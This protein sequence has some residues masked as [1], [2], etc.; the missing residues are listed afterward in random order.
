MCLISDILKLF[1]YFQGVVW[2]VNL[3]RGH[4]INYL[5]P[6]YP[7]FIVPFI[8]SL[9]KRTKRKEAYTTFV[10]LCHCLPWKCILSSRTF[11]TL[12][13]S[14]FFSSGS[15]FSFLSVLRNRFTTFLKLF[16]SAVVSTQL[17]PCTFHHF[18]H[19]I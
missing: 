13:V 15:L 14:D 7:L 5:D 16:A 19:H 6:R 9:S 1:T 3:C 8:V 12:I 11:Q 18:L 10:H 2:L 17:I 4:D